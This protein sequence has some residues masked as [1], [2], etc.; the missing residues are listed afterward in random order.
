MNFSL[1][2]ARFVKRVFPK[3]PRTIQ[4][5]L[6]QQIQEGLA[7]NQ[8]PSQRLLAAYRSLRTIQPDLAHIEGTDPSI[9]KPTN[10]FSKLLGQSHQAA[11][12]IVDEFLNSAGPKSNAMLH[13]IHWPGISKN[14]LSEFS[15]PLS[16]SDDSYTPDSLRKMMA[17][18]SSRGFGYLSA[19]SRTGNIHVLK[20]LLNTN[21]SP[22]E[23]N[24]RGNPLHEAVAHRQYECARLLLSHHVDTE[25]P[26]VLPTSA[27]YT[28]LV[29]ACIAGDQKMT[30]ILLSNGANPWHRA[31]DNLQNTP[32]HSCAGGA[33][34]ANTECLR[35]LLQQDP[36]LALARNSHQRTPLHYAAGSG[37]VESVKILLRAGADPNSKD[38]NGH[39]PLHAAWITSLNIPAIWAEYAPDRQ[40][41]AARNMFYRMSAFVQSQEHLRPL[42]VMA[43]LVAAGADENLLDLE[44]GTPKKSTFL[45]LLLNLG[46]VSVDKFSSNR[47]SWAQTSFSPWYSSF[48]YRNLK[49]TLVQW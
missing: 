41:D 26:F 48:P 14:D 40:S 5:R 42:E 12:T 1:H 30:Q 20:L 19:A 45:F 35:L 25:A 37:N 17:F 49:L 10:D 43:L 38:I 13:D 29:L 47:V 3:L 46:L 28:P 2:N 16:T 9:S 21:P 33:I 27:H 15:F 6:V 24:S 34:P 11:S 18:Q 7:N 39:S 23:I 31:L 22:E 32:A 36:R 8:E 44:E 4:Q